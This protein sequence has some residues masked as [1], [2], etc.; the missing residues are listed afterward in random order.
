MATL[1]LTEQAVLRSLKKTD[2]LLMPVPTGGERLMSW[3]F[4]PHNLVTT[5]RRLVHVQQKYKFLSDVVERIFDELIER[6]KKI[7]QA[8]SDEKILDL[9]D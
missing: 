5:K 4:V 3:L 9:Y 7:E 1:R 2:S 8:T 6:P